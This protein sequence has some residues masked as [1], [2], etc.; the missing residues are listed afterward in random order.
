MSPEPQPSYGHGSVTFEKVRQAEQQAIRTAF[1]DVDDKELIG[2]A[3][4]GG[5]IRSGTFGVGVPGGLK[6]LNLLHRVHYLSTVSGG[7]YIG[8]WFS[9]NCRRGRDRGAARDWR[10]SRGDGS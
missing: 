1:G 4:S 8:G 2:L 6:K 7:G 5:G 10:S 9:A 3:F